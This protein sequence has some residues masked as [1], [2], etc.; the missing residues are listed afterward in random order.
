M[1][2]GVPKKNTSRRDSSQWTPEL[3]EKLKRRLHII[4]QASENSTGRPQKVSSPGAKKAAWPPQQVVATGV[5]APIAEFQS[6]EEVGMGEKSSGSPQPRPA[7]LQSPES[8]LLCQAAA[9]RKFWGASQRSGRNRKLVTARPFSPC[10]L[11]F[12][13]ETPQPGAGSAHPATE[14]DMY[15][16]LQAEAA[17][18][19]PQEA[20]AGLPETQVSP[21]LR[22]VLPD[23]DDDR[24]PSWVDGEA[25]STCAG[26]A[27][28]HDASCW[29]QA[30]PLATQ[31]EEEPAP[32][33]TEAAALAARSAMPPLDLSELRQL[34][35][36]SSTSM[37]QQ[38]QQQQLFRCA[39][40][41]RGGDGLPASPVRTLGAA[42]DATPRL[43]SGVGGAGASTCGLEEHNIGQDQDFRMYTPRSPCKTPRNPLDRTPR[44]TNLID[45]RECNLQEVTSSRLDAA[46]TCASSRSA[47]W[48][49]LGGP[50]VCSLR[51]EKAIAKGEKAMEEEIRY[52]SQMLEDAQK[53]RSILQSI[54]SEDAAS[55]QRAIS[56]LRGQLEQLRPDVPK[57]ELVEKECVVLLR[58]CKADETCKVGERRLFL[59]GCLAGGEQCLQGMGRLC[60][61]WGTGHSKEQPP[62]DGA[63]AASSP[64]D[65]T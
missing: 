24:E 47:L 59:Q 2:P 14:E 53:E 9:A 30:P 5:E 56:E 65:S 32:L 33:C 45:F 63:V 40:G 57:Q 44:V 20:T 62:R 1:Q 38:Q 11:L 60:G 18:V 34:S 43:R 16:A 13:G 61:S 25:S 19:R 6:R 28:F 7:V 64:R 27:A 10:T 3:S 39:L 51:S 37:S 50:P 52:L 49:P 55:K 12:G 22:D 8:P 23:V 26:S 15:Q 42:R 17:M 36:K 21:S 29:V 4:E 35:G 48:S 41:G 58:A 31:G 46:S 54:S